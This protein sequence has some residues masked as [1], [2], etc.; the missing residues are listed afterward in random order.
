MSYIRKA[1]KLPGLGHGSS[2]HF[3]FL[4]GLPSQVPPKRSS[5]VLFLSKSWNPPP[6]VFVHSV[7]CSK[8]PHSHWT[9]RNKN[10]Y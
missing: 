3:C 9:E 5:L 4:T 7:T 10:Y 1:T 2:L 6:Q 8:G